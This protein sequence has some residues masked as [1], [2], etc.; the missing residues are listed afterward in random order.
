ME[1]EQGHLETRVYVALSVMAR[2]LPL[3]QGPYTQVSRPVNASRKAQPSTTNIPPAPA[4]L[5]LDYQGEYFI[6]NINDQ[7][8]KFSNILFIMPTPASSFVPCLQTKNC[9]NPN[10]IYTFYDFKNS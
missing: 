2:V 1:R 5:I 6:V 3:H 10:A 9:A 8:Y 7:L 4:G